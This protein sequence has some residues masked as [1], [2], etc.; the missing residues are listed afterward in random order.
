MTG[1]Y[2]RAR[3]PVNMYFVYGT[4]TTVATYVACTEGN[5]DLFVYTGVV[6]RYV[7]SGSRSYPV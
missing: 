6:S 5:L 7:Y 1:A 3:M 4:C 2:E